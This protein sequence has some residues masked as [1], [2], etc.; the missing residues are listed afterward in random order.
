MEHRI[1]TVSEVSHQEGQ[2]TFQVPAPMPERAPD[3][4]AIQEDPEVARN[5][6]IMKIRQAFG[7]GKNGNHLLKGRE[8]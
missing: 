3:P 2:Q 5:P 8:H 4:Q 6:I 7:S 1:D